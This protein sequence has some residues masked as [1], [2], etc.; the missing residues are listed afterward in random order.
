[1][2]PISRESILIFQRRTGI[3]EFRALIWA[4]QV[5]RCLESVRGQNFLQFIFFN[6]ILTY[7]PIPFLPGFH[8]FL[9]VFHSKCFC[10]FVLASGHGAVMQSHRTRLEIIR[11]DLNPELFRKSNLK[12]NAAA[13]SSSSSSAAAGG[14]PA[15]GGVRFAAPNLPNGVASSAAGGM[16]NLA[17][18][19]KRRTNKKGS[20]T[21]VQNLLS[22]I[23]LKK[24]ASS[25]SSTSSSSSESFAGSSAA[26]TPTVSG[27]DSLIQSDA[28][29]P[30]SSSFASSASTAAEASASP[31]RDQDDQDE[32]DMVDDGGDD[33]DQVGGEYDDE[34][35]EAAAGDAD[36]DED[37][38]DGDDGGDE[39][40]SADS[41]LL[42]DLLFD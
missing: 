13:S 2:L 33:G 8:D 22:E 27:L 20:S 31:S 35:D 12:A 11:R 4:N 25:T 10:L 23:E 32:A 7:D 15:R 41:G 42:H 21:R 37:G 24:G 39:E 38:G 26:S 1:L 16:T 6:I 19:R 17:A 30:S 14:A 36:G 3:F 29:L 5:K 40:Q 18:G 34:E 28:S 9:L